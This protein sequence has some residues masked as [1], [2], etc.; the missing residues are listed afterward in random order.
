[1]NLVPRSGNGIYAFK[2]TSPETGKSVS[3]STGKR[4]RAEAE[5]WAQRYMSENK[6]SSAKQYRKTL[7]ASLWDTYRRVWSKQK[8]AQSTYYKISLIDRKIGSWL[9]D[10]ITYEK[11]NDWYMS[12]VSGGRKPAT[13]GRDINIISKT[14]HEAHKLEWLTSV[15]PMPSIPSPNRRLRWLTRDEEEKLVAAALSLQPRRLM[16]ILVEAIPILADTGMRLGE[17]HKVEPENLKMLH[18]QEHIELLDT[19]NGGDRIVP[20][21]HRSAEAFQR[22]FQHPDWMSTKIVP[23][24]DNRELTIEVRDRPKTV[25]LSQQFR[26][27]AD[28]CEF[29]DVSLH[30]LR[31]TCASRLVQGGMDLYKVMKWLGH[32]DVKVTMIYAHLAPQH[33]AGGVDILSRC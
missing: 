15:P 9:L 30:T 21:T 17:L 14:L 10:Q 8:A 28:V 11:L 18:D 24:P 5:I 19:K 6:I 4:S 22:L 16:D 32:S 3:V 25:Q 1:M 12:E 20:L 2:Y 31:H 29:D 27:V 23:D 26:Y 7:S 33:L 13:V